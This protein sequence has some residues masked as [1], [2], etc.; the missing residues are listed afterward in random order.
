MIK[1]VQ[2]EMDSLTKNYVWVL[3]D[4]PEGQ[5]IVTS[6]WLYRI[7]RKANGDIDRYKAR[8]VA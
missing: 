8:L 2:E 3:V 4:K 1:A 5:N 7:K 6:M